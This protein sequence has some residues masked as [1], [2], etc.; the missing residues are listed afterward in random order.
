V[1]QSDEEYMELDDI[2]A[3][4]HTTVDTVRSY[5]RSKR[6]P[7]VMY[8]I[9]RKYLVKKKDFNAWMERNKQIEAES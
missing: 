9:G 2:A 1:N 4:L 8:K 3:I 6:N 7:L 5:R